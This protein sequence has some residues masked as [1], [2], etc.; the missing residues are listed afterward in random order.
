MCDTCMTCIRKTES[1]AGVPEAST[2]HR[3]FGSPSAR[4]SQT[5]RHGSKVHQDTLC[6]VFMVYNTVFHVFFFSVRGIICP[7][8]PDLIHYEVHLHEATKTYQ[9]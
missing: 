3:C 5:L 9:N 8:Y 7:K 6:H 4:R 1:D 2:H